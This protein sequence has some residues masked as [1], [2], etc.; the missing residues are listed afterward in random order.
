MIG[1]NMQKA[2]PERFEKV[3]LLRVKVRCTGPPQTDNGQSL[4]SS[5]LAHRG[6]VYPADVHPRY[7]LEH[8]ILF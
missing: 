7:T 4:V 8:P 2:P 5:T 1:V 3:T 6:Q